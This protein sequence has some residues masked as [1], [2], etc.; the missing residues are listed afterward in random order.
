MVVLLFVF[1]ILTSVF[2][3]EI[4]AAALDFETLWSLFSPVFD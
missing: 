4:L 3:F 2:C 1:I